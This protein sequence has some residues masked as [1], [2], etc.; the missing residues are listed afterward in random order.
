ME[1]GCGIRF[2]HGVAQF[3]CMGHMPRRPREVTVSAM[4]CYCSCCPCLC[5]FLANGVDW[6]VT[7]ISGV[8]REDGPDQGVD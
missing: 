5:C 3:V 8:V 4:R 2:V 1:A 7:G 6:S